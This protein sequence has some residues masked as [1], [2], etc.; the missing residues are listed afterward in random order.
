MVK[1]NENN[2]GIYKIGYDLD[3]RTW[4]AY[5]L[6]Y[7]PDNATNF[8]ASYVGKRIRIKIGRAHV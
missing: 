8:I 5:I 2:L 7:G 3:G 6:A 1:S 4:T